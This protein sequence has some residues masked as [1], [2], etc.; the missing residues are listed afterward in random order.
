MKQ[1]LLFFV[2]IA[3]TAV[4]IAQTTVTDIDGNVYNIV[5]IGDMKWTKENLKTTK[6]NDGTLVPV[7]DNATWANQQAIP[8]LG[9]LDNDDFNKDMGGYYNWYAAK[10]GKLCPSGWQVPSIEDWTAL[11]DEYGGLA[12]C[13]PYLQTAGGGKNESGFSI[14][15]LGARAYNLGSWAYNGV[16]SRFWAS[17]ENST[18][19]GTE[20]GTYSNATNMSIGGWFKNNGHNIRCIEKGPNKIESQSAKRATDVYPNPAECE[21]TLRVQNTPSKGAIYQIIDMQGRLIQQNSISTSET[22]ISLV[23]LAKSTYIIKVVNG[24][25]VT[26]LK[27]IKR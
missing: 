11:A 14:E 13:T 17:E 27:L 8:A 6:L 10:T 26:S 22:N 3:F 4:V 18:D 20:I 24:S 9:W 5:T 19:F 7:L 1:L 25:S 21:V 23:N 2:L 16:I 15:L 12:V